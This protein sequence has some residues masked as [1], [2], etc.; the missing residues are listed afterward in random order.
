[1]AIKYLHQCIISPFHFSLCGC[2]WQAEFSNS[3]GEVCN[4]WGGAPYLTVRRG[5]KLAESAAKSFGSKTE[6]HMFLLGGEGTLQNHLISL[7]HRNRGDRFRVREVHIF[8]NTH[9]E[10]IHIVRLTWFHNKSL[11]RLGSVKDLH[12]AKNPSEMLSCGLLLKKVPE[13]VLAS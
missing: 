3:E 12:H 4:R 9:T 5:L 6:L 7:R 1:M 11:S 2:S 10:H 13:A 8:K